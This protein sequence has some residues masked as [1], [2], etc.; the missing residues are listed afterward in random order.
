MSI[1]LFKDKDLT[2]NKIRKRDTKETFI[3]IKDCNQTI[4]IENVKTTEKS[5][6]NK[7]ELLDAYEIIGW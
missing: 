3:V 7:I 5:S 1:N 2:L 6:I 4:E